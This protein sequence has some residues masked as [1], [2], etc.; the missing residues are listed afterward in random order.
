[1]I[2][3]IRQ[4]VLQA[5]VRLALRS[6][7]SGTKSLGVS[8]VESA[9]LLVLFPKIKKSERPNTNKTA[10]TETTATA[11]FQLRHH[12]VRRWLMSIV[13]RCDDICSCVTKG[14]SYT[15]RNRRISQYK[16]T[17]KGLSYTPVRMNLYGL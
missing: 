10:N 4:Q 7:V 6:N 9:G 2:L 1:M 14:L 16:V 15:M 13:W 8:L 12:T 5:P 17:I 11:R 3:V